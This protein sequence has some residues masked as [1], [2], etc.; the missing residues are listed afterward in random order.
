MKNYQIKNT[1]VKNT[2]ASY[3][4]KIRDKLFVLRE[5]IFKIAEESEDVGQIEE[6]LKWDNPSYITFSPKSGTTIRLSQ[7]SVLK[8][9][10]RISVHCQTSLIA[11]FK[12]IYPQLEYDG[13]RSII[14][15]INKKLPKNAIEHF[16]Y[17]ALSYHS[18]K[19]LGI[20]I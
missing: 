3:S 14:F 6:T 2:Y 7:D 11:E 15:D 13:N 1:N 17:L 20:G 9:K 19:K 12:E 18:R 4:K 10:F 5:L 8:E 16:I